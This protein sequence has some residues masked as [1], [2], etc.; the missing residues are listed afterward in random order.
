ME[1]SEQL[2]SLDVST[3]SKMEEELGGAT[4]LT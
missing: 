3:R 4:E 2:Q 1:P